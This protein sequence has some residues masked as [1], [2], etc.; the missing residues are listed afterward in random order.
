MA[1]IFYHFTDAPTNPASLTARLAVLYPI[2]GKR[3]QGPQ[4]ASV[5]QGGL[6]ALLE[7]RKLL[8]KLRDAGW[9]TLKDKGNVIQC[10]RNCPPSMFLTADLDKCPNPCNHPE[11]CPWCCGRRVMGLFR[12]IQKAIEPGDRL[13]WASGRYYDSLK[14]NCNKRNLQRHRDALTRLVKPNLADCRGAH[15]LITVEPYYRDGKS[16][17]RVVYRIVA[18]LRKGGVFYWIPDKWRGRLFTKPDER[19]LVTTLA[20]VLRYPEYLFRGEPEDVVKILHARSD[21]RLSES[22]G[23][24]RNQSISSDQ[25]AQKDVEPLATISCS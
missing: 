9:A 16:R 15:W 8:S 17:L 3:I 1:D 23:C 20:R 22:Y 14:S 24:F 25:R 4:A 10:F 11:I 18:L 13:M 5:M 7:Y 6:A 21:L 19:K 12:T 2:S